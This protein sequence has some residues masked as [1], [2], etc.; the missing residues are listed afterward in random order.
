MANNDNEKKNI[1]LE[2]ADV[3]SSTGQLSISK[4]YIQEALAIDDSFGRAYIKLASIYG[5]AVSS[6]TENRKLEARDK[7]VYWV[8]L[9]YLNRA[10]SVDA[11]VTNTVNSQLA[12]YQA[13]TPSTEDKFFTLGYEQGQK[14]RVN[15]D[16]D[17]CYNWI[18][19]Y[20]IVR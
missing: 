16:L 8:V 18:S 1:N 19:E 12:T 2:L 17:N 6:C 10:K 3:Y 5:Q 4:K 20:T 7:V 11:S 9:D 15:G 13:V 14:V